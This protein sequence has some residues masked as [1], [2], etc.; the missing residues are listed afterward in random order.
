[1][2]IEGTIEVACDSVEEADVLQAMI[3]AAPSPEIE[4]WSR[5]GSVF[6]LTICAEVP[7]PLPPLPVE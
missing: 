5:E 3:E 6:G 2:L 1:M 4:S 7:S